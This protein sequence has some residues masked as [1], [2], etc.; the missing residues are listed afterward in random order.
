MK[1]EILINIRD[2]C[3]DEIESG[4]P[5]NWKLVF[6]DFKALEGDIYAEFNEHAEDRDDEYYFEYV[7]SSYCGE[8]VAPKLLISE[9]KILYELIKNHVHIY[10]GHEFRST[11]K[12]FEKCLDN[13]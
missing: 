10:R 11:L 9:F 12:A 1:N 7:L 3:P 2:G 5:K 4:L 13:I 6:R 8:V